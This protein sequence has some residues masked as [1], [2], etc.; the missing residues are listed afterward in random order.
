MSNFPE[1]F[2]E[3]VKAVSEVENIYKSQ[4]FSYDTV[5]RVGSLTANKKQRK[6]KE[7][8]K[9]P[10]LFVGVHWSTGG[11]SGG[12]CWDGEATRFTSD[13]QPGDMNLVLCKILQSVGKDK[14]S[15]VD[16]YLKIASL[17]EDS[18]F[19]ESEYYGNCTEYAVKCVSLQKLYAVLKEI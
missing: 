6:T 16:Y 17:F 3:F 12:N 8:D 7:E 4:D 18:D 10:E 13:E 1:T 2:E 14:I 15:F 5:F 11:R 9:L 19:T